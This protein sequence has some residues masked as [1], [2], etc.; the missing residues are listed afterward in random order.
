[1]QKLRPQKR[2]FHTE[3]VVWD[4]G[5]SNKSKEGTSGAVS[6]MQRL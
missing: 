5:M 4:R 6:E 1:M 3:V 2:A